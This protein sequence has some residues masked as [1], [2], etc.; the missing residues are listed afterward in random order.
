MT[1]PP[2]AP[3]RVAADQALTWRTPTIDVDATVRDARDVMRRTGQRI[4]L[5]T[6]ASLPVGVVTKRELWGPDGIA[7]SSEARVGD[8]LHLEVI[9]IE[10]STDV[11]RTLRRYEDAAWASLFRRRPGRRVRE[12]RRCAS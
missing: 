3:V 8:V 5:V 2:I 12:A 11:R 9:R 10:P 7:P 4:L 1:S 6:S